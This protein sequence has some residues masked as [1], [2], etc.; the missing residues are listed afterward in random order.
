MKRIPWLLF[1]LFVGLFAA[2]CASTAGSVNSG[3]YGS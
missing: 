2:G 1:A 3:G